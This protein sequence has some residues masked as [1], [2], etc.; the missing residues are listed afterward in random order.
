MFSKTIQAVRKREA[1]AEDVDWDL[2]KWIQGH[3][4]LS[5]YELAKSIAWSHG[6][7]YSSVKRLEQD[8]LVTVEKVIRNCRSASIVT[9]R[10]WQEFFTREELNE[11]QQPGYF[12]EIEDLL[13]KMSR[14]IQ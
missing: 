7:V 5:I 2:Y 3:P 12:D 4:G 10:K 6:K 11:M 8:G 9:Y 1:Q 13:K 14:N